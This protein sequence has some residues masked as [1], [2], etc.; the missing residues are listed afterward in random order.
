MKKYLF[1]AVAAIAALSS[2]SSDNEVFNS[3][4]KKALTFTATMENIGGDTRTTFNA[5]DKLAEWEV[6]D[7]VLI[8]G[9]VNINPFGPSDIE[10]AVYTAQSAG[11][12]TSFMPKT[13]GKEVSRNDQSFFAYFPASLVDIETGEM[14]LPATITAEYGKFN[15][16]M[17]GKSFLNT[18]DLTFKNIC[19]ILAI[20]VNNEQLTQVS[21]IKV[22]SS[23]C[24]TSGLFTVNKNNQCQIT[25]NE[26]SNT[27]TVTYTEPVQ[28]EA[29]G[30]V[31]YV[32]IPPQTYRNLK[33]EVSDGTTTKSMTTKKDADILVERNKI[34]NI[35]FKD[36]TPTTGTATAKING[37]E[38]EVKWIQLWA[39]GPKFAE[40]NIGTTAEKPE[41]NLISFYVAIKTG[42]DYAWGA[43]W[44]TPS[45]DE[46][47]QLRAASYGNSEAAGAKVTC[48]RV[49]VDGIN[50]F[51]FTGKEAG[52][53]DNKVFFPADEI[54]LYKSQDRVITSHYWTCTYDA[55][56]QVLY[57][58]SSPGC[59]RWD[60]S[61][62][63]YND[64]YVRP[65]LN[66]AK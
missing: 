23:N 62:K 31:F 63:G 52:Y 5:T 43:K 8:Y 60:S 61:A 28:T 30:K 3:E 36:N 17:F 44:R 64:Y 29:T 13:E 53:T 19:G 15:M 7:E 18:P 25:Q 12:T 51:I 26:P 50:G 46:M 24:A 2:C 42:D 20:T 39:G 41:G 66:E 59:A 10:S 54:D 21:S 22:S 4:V 58:S 48:E 16:P 57:L 27:V 32:A 34:Y 38:V 9:F 47:D 1:M 55:T 65:V 35:T 40:Y 33:I 56:V 11:T 45:K 14:E 49:I 37:E 6:G